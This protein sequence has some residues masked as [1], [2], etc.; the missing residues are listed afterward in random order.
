[1]EIAGTHNG[2]VQVSGTWL[3]WFTMCYLLMWPINTELSSCSVKLANQQLRQFVSNR[4]LLDLEL[5]V[6][7]VIADSS[8]SLDVD[9]RKWCTLLQPK[10]ARLLCP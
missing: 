1:M 7:S 10:V 9:M 4:Q 2:R 5:K 3:S 8:V 6:Q